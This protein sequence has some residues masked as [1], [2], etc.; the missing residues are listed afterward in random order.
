LV[1][2]RRA[3]EREADGRKI[4]SQK[5]IYAPVC[6]TQEREGL[7]LALELFSLLK[8]VRNDRE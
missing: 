3:E 6:Y 7:I 4:E 8:K 1:E 5:Y 2:P